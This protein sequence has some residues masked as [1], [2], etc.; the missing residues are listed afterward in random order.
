MRRYIR[1]M[2]TKEFNEESYEALFAR[3][4][5]STNIILMYLEINK[6]SKENIKT[7]D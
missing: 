2:E 7:E 3:Y 5:P 6:V 4:L 1:V